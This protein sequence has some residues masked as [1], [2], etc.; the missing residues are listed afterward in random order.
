M[1]ILRRRWVCH[2]QERNMR[3]CEKR[4]YRLSPGVGET[5]ERTRCLRAKEINIG[6]VMLV[7]VSFQEML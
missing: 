2:G 5:G 3:S 1:L 6:K 7:L 4:P